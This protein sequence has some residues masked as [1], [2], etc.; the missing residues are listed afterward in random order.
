MQDPNVF[1]LTYKVF[2]K[3]NEAKPSNKWRRLPDNVAECSR[4]ADKA[5]NTNDDETAK[6]KRGAPIIP[7]KV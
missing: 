5:R 6:R 1:G 4:L 2:I 7:G 3:S